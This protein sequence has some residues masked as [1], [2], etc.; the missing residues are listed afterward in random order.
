[1]AIDDKTESYLCIADEGWMSAALNGGN[2]KAI[3]PDILI[4]RNTNQMIIEIGNFFK[5]KWD[6]YPFAVIQV[7]HK[8][9]VGLIQ[10]EANED[11]KFII[12]KC[13]EILGVY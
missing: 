8:K 12:D 2:G 5:G 11:V 1:M 6:H 9:A 7:S 10:G 3:R 4:E 13:R